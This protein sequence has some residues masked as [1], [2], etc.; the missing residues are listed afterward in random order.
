MK[1]GFTLPQTGTVAWQADQVARYASEVEQLGGDSLWVIDRLLSP[2]NPVIGYNGA[3]TFPEEF[4][5]ILDPFALLA[6][7]ATATER[8][9]IGSNILNTPW[10]PPALLA[11]TLTTL[12][13]LSGG[14]L[15]PGLGVGWSPEEYDAVGVPMAERGAR[16]DETLDAL[17]RLWTEDPASYEG[18]H[19][20]VPETRAALKPV[21][22]PP[23]Y[24]AGF[25]PASMRRVA[26][27]ADGWL[28]AVVLPGTVDLDGAV[29]QPLAAIRA[30]A[31]EAGRD[32]GALDMI[33]RIYPTVRTGSVVDDVTDVIKRVEG[34]TEVRHVLVDLMYQADDIDTLLKQVQGIL[35]AA[36]P[37]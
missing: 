2:P 8:V 13:V 20:R 27:R 25:A 15:V 37:A 26:R 36:R 1:I 31:A 32:P 18:K 24:L 29:N 19:V 6:V 30:M 33:L 35:S 4:R 17:D 28:P 16:L 7:A 14:R 5:A 11:R 21:R 9:L 34:E 22:K 3:D 12:D 23:V 10:Y